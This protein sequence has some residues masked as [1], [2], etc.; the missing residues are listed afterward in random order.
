MVSMEEYRYI[1][2]DQQEDYDLNEYLVR[3]LKNDPNVENLLVFARSF[4]CGIEAVI[5]HEKGYVPDWGEL[6]R[7]SK[8]YHYKFITTSTL[9]VHQQWKWDSWVNLRYKDG[10]YHKTKRNIVMEDACV[11]LNK[12][13]ADLGLKHSVKRS[14][15][16]KPEWSKDVWGYTYWKLDASI[17]GL[18]RDIAKICADLQKLG[19]MTFFGTD[20]KVSHQ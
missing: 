8:I 20:C 14:G 19:I 2:A 18:P 7:Q 11:H 17:Q 10:S 4:N 13:C 5:A 12:V 9:E 6:V 3:A 1:Y 15:I 16:G